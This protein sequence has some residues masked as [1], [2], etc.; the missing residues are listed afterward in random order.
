MTDSLS[1]ERRSWNMSRIRG[2]HTGPEMVLRQMLH[3][4]GFRYRIHDSKLR[5]KPDIILP[6]YRTVIFVHG[7][8]WHRHKNCRDAT[9]PKT[10]TRFW[11]DKLNGNVVR[12]IRNRR[13]LQRQGWSTLTVWECQL[14]KPVPIVDRVE[15]RLRH[16]LEN[17]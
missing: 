13:A 8:F 3:K 12:D 5:G 15:R 16:R 7:C 14:K 11:L 2:K 1:T 6:K 17:I 9:V 10:R 4:R